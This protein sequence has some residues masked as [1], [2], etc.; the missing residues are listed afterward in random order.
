MHV[1]VVVAIELVIQVHMIV[2]RKKTLF[3]LVMVSST[4]IY[5]HTYPPDISIYSIPSE[6]WIPL[7]NKYRRAYFIIVSIYEYKRV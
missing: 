5:I 4:S 6:Q 1:I 3:K 2:C 7:E